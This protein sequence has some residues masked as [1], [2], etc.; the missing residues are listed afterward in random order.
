MHLST[1][2]S[3]QSVNQCVYLSIYLLS[4]SLFI[5]LSLYQTISIYVPTYMSIC[6]SYNYNRDS[7]GAKKLQG[8]NKERLEKSVNLKYFIME[9]PT[10]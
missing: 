3:I 7:K 1:Y 6:Q 2:L 4:I 10:Y 5:R 9:L 8:E